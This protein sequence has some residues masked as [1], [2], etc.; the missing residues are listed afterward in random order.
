MNTYTKNMEV[1]TEY[2][3]GNAV[4][5]HPKSSFFRVILLLGCICIFFFCA[6]AVR[7]FLTARI[8]RM[9]KYT[10][11]ISKDIQDHEIQCYHLRNRKAR[12]TSLDYISARISQHKLNLR[13]ADYR[14]VRTV[15]LLPAGRLDKYNTPYRKSVSVSRS[16]TKTS[17][18]ASFSKNRRYTQ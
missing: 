11:R 12:L 10:A 5:V 4:P 14:Q 13:S 8:E 2:D 18:V 1:R 9:N 7:V 17:A 6:I 16:R 15:A 3:P